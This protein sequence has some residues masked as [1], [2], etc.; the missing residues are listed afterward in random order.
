MTFADANVD[1]LSATTLPFRKLLAV[2]EFWIENVD[3]ASK[4]MKTLEVI[5]V[6]V[7]CA[8]EVFEWGDICVR[9]RSVVPEI[10][11]MVDCKR[12]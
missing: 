4:D 6:R 8:S 10:N 9:F 3:R 7:S 11:C 12:P 1:P 2:L 5:I